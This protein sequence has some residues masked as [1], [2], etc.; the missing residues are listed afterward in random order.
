[1]LY[2]D[3]MAY[4]RFKNEFRT[5]A[6]V[7]HTNLVRLYEFVSKSG[8]VFFTMELVRGTDFREHVQAP[9]R[10]KS[11]SQPDAPR[12]D[13]PTTVTAPERT[14][15]GSARTEPMDAL[16]FAVTEK[17]V[18][19]A[20]VL[21]IM[22][23]SPANFKRLSPALRQLVEG[24][25]ALHAAGML[26]RDIKPSNVLVTDDGRVVLLDFGIA[27]RLSPQRSSA[28]EVLG[29]ADYMAPELINGDAP[30]TTAS[31][32]YSVGVVLYETL[33][34]Q[35][36]FSGSPASVFLAKCTQDPP[37]ASTSVVGVPAE[38]DRLCR[39]LLDRDPSRRPPANEILRVLGGKPSSIPPPPWLRTVE[40]APPLVG[41]EAL[42]GTL[43]DAFASVCAGRSLTARVSGPSGVGKSSLVL[44]FLQELEA[45]GTALVLRGR[46]YEREAIPY[47]AVDAVLDDLTCHL[48][49]LARE[50]RPAPIPPDMGALARL[51]PVLRRLPWVPADDNRAGRAPNVVRRQAFA[52]L[53]WLLAMLGTDRPVVI[54]LDDVHWGDVDSAA[55]LLEL[56]RS[57]NAPPLLLLMAYRDNESDRS[58]FLAEIRER[59]PGNAEVRELAIAPLRLEEAKTLALDRLGSVD[60]VAQSLADAIARESGGNPFLVEELVRSNR[61]AGRPEPGSLIVERLASLPSPARQVMEL[62][63]IAARP[64]PLSV[65][66]A[67]AGLPEGAEEVFALLC[68]TRFA[69]VGLRDRH[70]FI[71]TTHDRIGEAIVAQLSPSALRGHHGV[72][73]RA[74]EDAPGTDVEAVVHHW[75][76]ADRADRA[77]QLALAAAEKAAAQLAFEQASRLYRLAIDHRATSPQGVSQLRERLAEALQLAGRN[78]AAAE[79]YRQAAD[80]T[81]PERRL[82]LQRAAAEQ[83][84][85]SGRIAKGSEVL[86]SVLRAVGV[87]A[88]RAP[89]AI[90][91]WLVIYRLWLFVLG[92]RFKERE[93]EEVRPEDSLRV[94]ALFTAALTFS[95]VDPIVGACMQARHLVE[96]LRVGSRF[97]VLRAVSIEAT[98]LAGR[99]GRPSRR[100]RELPELASRLAERH[101]TEEA[102]DFLL[103]LLGMSAFQRG[104]W[105]DA[106]AALDALEG[107]TSL[108]RTALTNTRIFGTVT[109]AELGELREMGRQAA[110]LCAAAQDRGDAFTLVNLGAI[111]LI[112]CLVEDDPDGA[113]QAGRASLAHW[114][115][116]GFHVE[117]W[118]HMVFVGDVDLYAGET[119]HA[120]DRFMRDMP[121]L[122]KSFLLQLTYV[123][124]MT[125]YTRV[126]LAIASIETRPELRSARIAEARRMARRLEREHDAW[127]GVLA[128]MGQ[129]MA[130]NASGDRTG[131]IAAL[132]AAVARADATHSHYYGVPARYRLGE[133]LGGAEGGALVE[134]ARA[135]L[136]AQGVRNIACW[137]A[138]FLPGRWEAVTK[139]GSVLTSAIPC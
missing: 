29:T 23:R 113:R 80:T 54:F 71:E 19:G 78:T 135:T 59:W 122:E 56:V 121:K 3:P 139:G 119:A 36:P 41:R 107:R 39:S 100:E 48:I 22:K 21:P 105:R 20:G 83:L 45:N 91:L 68:R 55:L 74:L 85:L 116:K 126:R 84:L 35:T 32:W 75:L 43:R 10:Q 33:V 37:L 88:P 34:G 96:A 61:K 115:K 38:L 49:H 9:S 128:A 69:R 42:L 66:Q 8:R 77:A 132:R 18:A 51:F 137:A 24:V 52:S 93:P 106:R 82:E 136:S 16:P 64:L 108:M 123:R 99:G 6:D 112:H 104:R 79:A 134:Q 133:L 65:V 30:Y 87:R 28:H 14:L 138:I 11:T 111:E 50:G 103:A 4:Y 5:L 89:V 94:D 73:A 110:R 124:A 60:Q 67:A 117:H 70:E 95:F 2:D 81:Q 57:P 86:Y 90:I 102:R 25:Q 114:T 47:K 40:A 26:H 131:A 63:A 127:I 58:P 125:L 76:E 7:Q 53:R 72:L 129:A 98:H 31:D 120:Y 101:D 1:M 13:Q 62:V 12:S 44:R 46:A 17:Y 97:Q 130:A 118:L 109:L 15:S 92:L 27:T